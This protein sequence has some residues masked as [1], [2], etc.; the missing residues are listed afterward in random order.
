MEQIKAFIEKVKSDNALMAKL[1]AL[2][3][4][5]ASTDDVIKLAAEC[6]F[7]FS[8]EDYEQSKNCGENCTRCGELSVEDLDTVSGGNSQNRYD[9]NVCPNLTR[10]RYECVGFMSWCYCDHYRME[11]VKSIGGLGRNVH[12][13]ICGMGA[14]NYEGLNN[15]EPYNNE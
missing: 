5:N 2:S 14:F 15:G 10:T 6:G 7:T 3:A 13:H 12:Q 11:Y 8:K 4:K 9:P 1:D